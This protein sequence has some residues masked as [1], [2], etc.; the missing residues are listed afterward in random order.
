MLPSAL[1]AAKQPS[2][3]AP[4]TQQVKVHGMQAVCDSLRARGVSQVLEE[5]HSK[6]ISGLSSEVLL[7]LQ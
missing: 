1:D 4:P 7:F 2:L 3:E 5:I 6:T